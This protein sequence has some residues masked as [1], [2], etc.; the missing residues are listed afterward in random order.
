MK[1]II[2]IVYILSRNRFSKLVIARDNLL[3]QPKAR[4]LRKLLAKAI[5]KFIQEDIIY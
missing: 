4:A 1:I 3:G 2:N 5:T